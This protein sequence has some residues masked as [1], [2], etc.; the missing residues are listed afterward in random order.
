MDHAGNPVTNAITGFHQAISA[1]ALTVELDIQSS[2]FEE[3][4]GLI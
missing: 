2:W 3:L 4:F 1:G